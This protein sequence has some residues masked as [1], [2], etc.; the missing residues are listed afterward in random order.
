[1]V[2]L[3][4]PILKLFLHVLP[5]LRLPI[6]VNAIDRTNVLEFIN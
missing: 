3:N 6:K 2:V 1:M 5:S 4:L